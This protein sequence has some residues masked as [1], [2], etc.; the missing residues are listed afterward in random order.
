MSVRYLKE[1]FQENSFT[2]R[3]KQFV[4]IRE[5][6]GHA[7]D[8]RSSAFICGDWVCYR[9][10]LPFIQQPEALKRSGLGHFF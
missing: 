6:R 10:M 3:E 8:L 9:K 4:L 5:I 1:A 7:F 2:I